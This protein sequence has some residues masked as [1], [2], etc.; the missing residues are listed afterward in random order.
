ML[1]P[2]ILQKTY[3]CYLYFLDFI[4]EETE[5]QRGEMNYPGSQ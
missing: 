3:K 2:L 4:D 1:S 5:A